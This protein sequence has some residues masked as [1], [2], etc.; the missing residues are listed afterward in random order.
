[1]SEQNKEIVSKINK[2]FEENKP[3]D[4]LGYCAEDIRWEMAGE[5]THS[6]KESIRQFMSSMEGMEPPR[7]TVDAT[8]AEGDHVVCF[9]NMA[10][11][12]EGEEGEYSYCDVYRFTDGKVSELRSYV[13]KKKTQG[14]SEKSASA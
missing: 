3:E 7:F 8:V 4:F 12:M 11:K 14:E 2:A 6:G 5:G 1:M 9:G 13:V 10:M